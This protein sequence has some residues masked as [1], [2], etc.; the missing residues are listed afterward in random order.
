MAMSADAHRLWEAALGQLQ[1]QTTRANFDTWLRETE[2]LEYDGRELRVGVASD[3]A[4]EW[5][6]ERMAPLIRK[7]LA[8]IEGRAIAVRFVVGPSSAATPVATGGP[9]LFAAHVSTPAA[10]PSRG[11]G[12]LSKYTFD[13]FVAGAS[14][15]LAFS[16]ARSVAEAPGTAYNPFYLY[17]GVGLGKTHLLHA[18]GNELAR[19]GLHVL[20]VSTERFTNEYIRAIL[21]R[22]FDEFRARYRTPDLLLVDDVQFLAGKEQMQE[23]FFHT[24]NEIYAAGRQIVLTSDRPPASISLLEDR[25]RSRFAWG[26]IADVQPPDHEMRVAILKAKAGQQ[27]VDLPA[28]VLEVIASR[29]QHNIRELEGVLTRVLAVARLQSGPITADLAE[30]AI[31]EMGP[32]HPPSPPLTPDNAIAAVARHFSL[33][34]ADLRGK[35]RTKTL[36]LARHVAMYLLREDACLPLAEIGRHMGG[37]DHTTVLHATTKIAGALIKDAT[38]RHDVLKIREALQREGGSGS[39]MR[40]S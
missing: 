38:L 11:A 36:A 32:D 26:L 9:E 37:R 4:R 8:A 16:A 28:P 5:L 25:L 21:D 19:Q 24:F 40:A 34:P 22:K 31:V 18:I 33:L 2:G 27:G 15:M 35:G 30:K 14:N 6:S 29:R 17:G 12:L 7:T 3:F 1:L 13:T 20:Y 39:R 10:R 23:E